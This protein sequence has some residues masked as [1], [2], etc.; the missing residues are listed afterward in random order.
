MRKDNKL[1]NLTHLGVKIVAGTLLAVFLVLKSRGGMLLPFIIWT[2]FLIIFI[3]YNRLLVYFHKKGL[4]TSWQAVEFYKKCREQNILSFKDENF[5][6]AKDI[7]FLI[8]E[9]DIYSGEGSLADH[10]A[11][12]YN[13]G[14][15]ITEK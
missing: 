14:K 1:F 11:N 4:Y 3:S 15:E 6:K 10:M 9:T 12:L 13:T 7:Y 5:E 2:V 8:F